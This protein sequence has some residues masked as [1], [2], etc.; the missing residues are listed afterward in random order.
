MTTALVTDRAIQIIY[1]ISTALFI[2]SLK[3]LSSPSSARRGVR[4]GECHERIGALAP[5]VANGFESD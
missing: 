1:L 2:L 5:E 4:A 3:W